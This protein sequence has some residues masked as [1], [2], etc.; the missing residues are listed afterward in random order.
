MSV[1]HLGA[2][3]ED[4]GAV[5]EPFGRSKVR[6]SGPKSIPK[7]NRFFDFEIW[8]FSMIFGRYVK[9][10][11]YVLHWFFNGFVQIVFFPK[12]AP[13]DQKR[14]VFG[15]QNGPESELWADISGPKI[16]KNSGLKKRGS[17]IEKSAS[18]NQIPILH[19][20][21]FGSQGPRKW[22]LSLITRHS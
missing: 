9:S 15:A 5:W 13:Q 3:G 11:T 16:D 4:L 14:S 17:Q 1:I 8:W 19:W 18:K 21:L 7:T 2:F 20:S 22:T 6:K 10:K 12:V